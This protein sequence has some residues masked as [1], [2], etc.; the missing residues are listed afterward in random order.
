MRQE[1]IMTKVLNCSIP[2][3]YKKKRDNNPSV[4]VLEK[5]FSK[6]DLKE[7]LETGRIE[8][9]EKMDFLQNQVIKKNRIKYLKSFTY[10]YGSLSKSHT[11]FIDFYFNFLKE[12]KDQ[13]E[14]DIGFVHFTYF[15]SFI[16]HDFQYLLTQYLLSQ[17]LMEYQKKI[18]KDFVNSFKESK[19]EYTDLVSQ[20]IFDYTS[21][22][23]EQLSKE[24]V[25]SDC[26][27]DILNNYDNLHKHFAIFDE[28]DSYMLLFLKE[29][30]DSDFKILFD[31]DDDKKLQEEALYHIKKWNELFN[32]EVG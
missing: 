32:Q 15:G 6:K 28:W 12:L 5:Y 27:L 26:R 24:S 31:E 29:C 17:S 13:E 25:R 1:E 23:V 18:D 7:F 4:L 30:L 22:E 3:Y 21:H 20:G 11:V 9:L 8:K 16:N 19:I 2:T 14:R 10:P